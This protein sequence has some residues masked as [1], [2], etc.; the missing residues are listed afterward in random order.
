MKSIVTNIAGFAIIMVVLAACSSQKMGTTTNHQVDEMINNQ[1]FTF[2][3]RN[4]I[5]TEDSRYSPRLMFPNA[6]NLY[7]L[8]SRYD[9]R[10]TPDSVIAYLPFFGR[11]Y[12]APIDPSEGGIKF[13]ST[14]FSYKNSIR[15]KNYEIQIN[16]S[17]TREAQTLYLTVSSSGYA[18]LTV[19]SYN[20]TPITFNGDIE[21]NH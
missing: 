9:V 14:K 20:R 19:L 17:D 10:V 11:A 2:V 12:T 3:A 7:Q 6:S 16:P 4:V 13:T 5:P 21:A 1:H 15:K 8:T 18:S